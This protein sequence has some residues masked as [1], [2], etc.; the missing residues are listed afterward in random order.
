VI[1]VLLTH[2]LSQQGGAERMLVET[3]RVWPEERDILH[4]RPVI[5]F[6]DTFWDTFD[7]VRRV[8]DLTTLPDVVDEMLKQWKLDRGAGVRAGVTLGTVQ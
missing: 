5:V 3:I 1:A 2:T 8:H 7:L 6:G 4:E